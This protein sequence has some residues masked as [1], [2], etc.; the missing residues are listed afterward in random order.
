MDLHNL[1]K[2]LIWWLPTIIF[3]LTLILSFLIGYKRG[4]RKS[5]ILFINSFISL[6]ICLILYFTLIN[7]KEVDAFLLNTTNNIMGEDWLQ[8]TL[9][10]SSSCTTLREVILEAIPKNMNYMDGLGLIL[11]ENGQYL[12][13]LVDLTYRIVFGL[14]IYILY[15]LVLFIE[16]IIYLIFFNEKKYRRKLVDDFYNGKSLVTYHKKSTLGGFV[17]LFR[18][19]IKAT[20]DISFI[21]MIFFIIAG[22]IGEREDSELDLGSDELNYIIDAYD[23][24][25]S[26]GTKGIFKVLNMCKDKNDV[27]YY[28]FAADLVFQG[29]LND[30]NRHIST[31]NIY[32]R[33]ELSA[34][35]KFSRD[36]IEL[37]LKYGDQDIRNAILY[38][39]DNVWN[40]L[41]PIFQNEE[42]Q[43]EFRVVINEFD[44]GTYFINLTLSLGVSIARHLNELSFTEEIDPITSDFLNILFNE[45][46]HSDVI[47]YERNL[48][49]DVKL[50]TIDSTLIVTKDDLDILYEIFICSINQMSMLDQDNPDYVRYGVSLGRKIIP[51]LSQLNILNTSNSKKLDP[52]LRRIYAYC[53]YKFLEEDINTNSI[54][55]SSSFY[56]SEEYEN[57]EWLNEINI[58]LDV[59]SD[60]SY[61]YEDILNSNLENPENVIDSIFDLFI[62]TNPKHDINKNYI[63]NFVSYASSSKMLAT[64]MKTKFITNYIEI[65]INNLFDS[66]ILPDEVIYSNKYDLEGNIVEYGELYNLLISLEAI[67]YDSNNA[68][69]IKDFMNP[70]K[71]D[72]VLPNLKNLFTSLKNTQYHQNT[73]FDYAA[74]STIINSILTS[75]IYNIDISDDIVIYKPDDIIYTYPNGA[76]T[77]EKNEFRVFTDSIFNLLDLLNPLIN[78]YNNDNLINVLNNKNLIKYFESK[79]IKYTLNDTLIN[80]LKNN[81]NEIIVPEA[82][83][84]DEIEIIVKLIQNYNISFDEVLNGDISQIIK[85]IDDSNKDSFYEIYSSNILSSNI[86]KKLDES[87]DSHIYKEIIDNEAIYDENTQSYNSDEIYNLL[88]SIHLLSLNVSDMIDSNQFDDNI[89]KIKTNIYDFNQYKIDLLWNSNIFSGIFSYQLDSILT[90]D[91]LGL[92]EMKECMHDSH[93]FNGN[94]NLFHYD[95]KEVYSLMNSLK[96]GLD[97]NSLD[98]IN[99]TTDTFLSLYNDNLINPSMKINYLYNSLLAKYI[100]RIKLDDIFVNEEA[101]KLDENTLDYCNVKELKGIDHD[102]EIYNSDELISFIKCIKNVFK[103]ENENDLKNFNYYNFMSNLNEESLHSIY[104]STLAIFILSNNLDNILTNEYILADVRDSNVIKIIYESEK[105][106]NYYKEEELKNLLEANNDFNFFL[107][108]KFNI[109]SQ[110]DLKEY[111]RSNLFKSNIILGVIT[112]MLD[113]EIKNKSNGKI[114]NTKLAYR[115]DLHVYKDEE[116]NILIDIIDTSSDDPLKSLNINSIKNSLES[117]YI[118]Q[119]TISKFLL[120]ESKNEGNI[121]VVDELILN[122]GI[123]L[124][125]NENKFID[126]YELIALLEASSIMGVNNVSDLTSFN[127][128]ANLSYMTEDIFESIIIRT[129]FPK[130]FVIKDSDDKEY[131]LKVIDSSKTDI[132]YMHLGD[133]EIRVIKKYAIFN[134]IKSI[135]DIA[136]KENGLNYTMPTNYN[137]LFI[138]DYNSLSES[139][140]ILI[141]EFLSEKTYNLYGTTITFGNFISEEDCYNLGNYEVNKGNL[142][143]SDNYEYL[144]M[145]FN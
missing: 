47:P 126:V 125:D 5:L 75:A 51:Y 9:G 20:V 86:S 76:I 120:D 26:Y 127:K 105:K 21:G 70:D 92:A 7:V 121:L 123:Y 32:F 124:N 114:I 73:A 67:V 22:G 111:N 46:Y 25:G 81:V 66:Y 95:R 17:G 98:N 69:I 35:T 132:D 140:I 87:L 50:P 117:S 13:T 138:Y 39:T 18:G 15:F 119:A 122:K 108:G 4:F 104:D 145:Y 14:V 53:D 1:I 79:I 141:S 28:L 2:Q 100:I 118:L 54:D 112:K 143:S 11:E 78:D 135:V 41:Y 38:G 106:V 102:Y 6:I 84:N 59:V 49:S 90:N 115:N 139:F 130:V 113:D 64:V 48:D 55:I 24:I 65:G 30:P 56:I 109:P 43:N 62:D 57:I 82:T 131:S 34:Y 16:Y 137:S 128:N 129:S 8:N 103:I 134:T 52:V 23:A 63:S 19:T 3:V 97:I 99:I 142:L 61:I 60:L 12:S 29:R 93:I 88:N 68:K 110:N 91:E 96:R 136:S 44:T 80:Y 45:Q 37:I 10:V 89:N 77:I 40:V 36:T 94:N 107:N 58:L 74:N 144:Q 33:K 116:L 71:Q 42:F 27:P 101:L 133:K 31:T 72:E 83:S 85:V